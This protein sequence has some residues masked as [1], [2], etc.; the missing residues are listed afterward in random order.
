[1]KLKTLVLSGLAS[2]GA[3]LL[4]KNRQEIATVVTETTNDI[5]NT[6]QAISKVK[7]NL[8]TVKQEQ[9]TLTNV[10]QDLGYKFR[11][12]N[13]ELQAHLAEIKTVMA[14]YQTPDEETKNKVR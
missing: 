3:F 12:F 8:A 4:Y 10:S 2:A 11:V 1:M 14:K 9:K 13:K 7:A 5:K 6:N